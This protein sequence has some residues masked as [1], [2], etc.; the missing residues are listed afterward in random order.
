MFIYLDES[1]DLGF[2]FEKESSTHFVITLLICEDKETASGFKVAVKRTIKRKLNR[3]KRSILTRELKS[4]QTLLSVKKYFLNI[5]RKQ[6]KQA[7]SIY[8]IILDKKE[9]LKK[10]NIVPEKHRLYNLLSKIILQQ[11]NFSL[12][13]ADKSVHLIVDRSKGKK[14]RDIFNQYLKAN[15]ELMLDMGTQFNIGH[16]ES[17]NNAGLQAT[18]LFCAGFSRKYAY[19]DKS[20]YDLFKDKICVE[21]LFNINEHK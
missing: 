10:I 9:L 15:I 2:N 14:Q 3:N 18:D 12:G 1:G 20:W 8:S 17:H 21:I 6:K 16:E 11:V 7:W 19:G 5:L 4:T 13:N